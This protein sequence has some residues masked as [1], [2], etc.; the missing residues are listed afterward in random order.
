MRV[1]DELSLRWEPEEVA[2]DRYPAVPPIVGR[3][4]WITLVET[5]ETEGDPLESF[6]EF[7]ADT[8][9][10]RR[11]PRVPRLFISHK[12]STADDAYAERIAE[13]ARAVGLHY[14]LDIHDPVL[15]RV[16]GQPFPGPQKGILIAAIIEMGLL[17]CA[18]VIAVHSVLSAGSKWIP[19][20]FGRV[21]V[22]LPFSRDAAGY[23]HPMVW[24][25][26]AAEY[27]ELAI[28]TFGEHSGPPNTPKNAWLPV[29][30]WL[31]DLAT[32]WGSLPST[33]SPSFP[34]PGPSGSPKLP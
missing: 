32:R 12:S 16:N 25:S 27:F 8:E 11:A 23:F 30:Q 34:V 33:A 21:K 28:K 19:Y 6:D 20:E 10:L 26:V 17:N 2:R 4:E 14:W 5:L 24:N 7:L 3:K 18:H 29:T 9:Q 22:H 1:I 31:T 15:L 13:L